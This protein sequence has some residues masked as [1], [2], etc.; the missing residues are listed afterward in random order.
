MQLSSK[1]NVQCIASWGFV[2]GAVIVSPHEFPCG[3]R[4]SSGVFS[5]SH[6]LGPRIVVFCEE[7]VPPFE[8][9]S[10]GILVKASAFP[11]SV[12]F[13]YMI[14]KSKFANF[15][16]HLACLRFNSL[17]FMNGTRLA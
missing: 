13:V 12:P 10:P 16:A 4:L 17:F 14:L 5:V 9:M 8:G 11:L 1:Q 3:I 2:L 15:S 6:L 7:S